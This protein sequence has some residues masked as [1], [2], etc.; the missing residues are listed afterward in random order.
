MLQEGSPK[1]TSD[2]KACDVQIEWATCRACAE[3]NP[4]RDPEPGSGT[5]TDTSPTNPGKSKSKP[6][7]AVVVAVVVI[8]ALVG[9]GGAYFMV[10]AERRSALFGGC[11]KAEAPK[12]R[13]S[14]LDENADYEASI[15]LTNGGADLFDESDDDSDDDDE[16]IAIE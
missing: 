14:K 3:E 5:G 1:V 12:F 2:A 7:G 13:Y 15:N 16:I 6:K 11:A 9:L 4:C 8:L 10:G